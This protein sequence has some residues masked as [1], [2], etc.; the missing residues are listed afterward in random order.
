MLE[1]KDL[2]ASVNGKEILKGINLTIKK[3]EVHALWDLMVLV[4]VLFH[5]CW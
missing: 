4:K 5:P 3:G 2:H 1:I